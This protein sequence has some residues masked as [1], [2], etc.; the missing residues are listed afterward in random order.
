VSSQL[1]SACHCHFNRPTLIIS[2][3]ASA[4]PW[5]SQE[6]IHRLIKAS[7]F[8]VFEESEGGQHFMFIENLEKLNRWS[9]NI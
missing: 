5:N 7:Q 2:G 3:R 6:W 4:V 8:E 9:W 1:L